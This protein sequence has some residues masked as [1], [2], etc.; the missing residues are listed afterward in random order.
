MITEA[1]ITGERIDSRDLIQWLE[2]NEDDPDEEERCEEIRSLEDC[3]EDW[4]YGAAFI[5]EDSFQEYAQELAEDIGAINRDLS[6]PLNCIDWE[7][8]AEALAMDYTTV[9]YDGHTYYVR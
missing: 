7:Q 3:C 5:R 4:I 8:A 2:E 1:Q 9:E 6:W